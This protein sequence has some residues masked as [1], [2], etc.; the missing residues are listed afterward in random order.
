[1]KIIV[2]GL[3]ISSSWGNGHATLWRGLCKHIIRAGHSVLFFER[4]VSYY[5]GARDLIELPGGRLELFSAWDD[6]RSK[7]RAELREADAAIVTS[8][9]PDGIAATDLVLDQDRALRVFYDLDTPVTLA[10]LQAGEPLSY[11]GPRGLKE[12]D[13]VLSFTGGERVRAQF[14]HRLGARDVE[15]LYGH[16]DPDVHRPA[17]PQLHYR[18]HLSY[19]GTYSGDR[20]QALENL[21]IQPARDRPELQFLIGGAQYPHDFPWSRNIYFVRH[22]PPSKHPAFFASSRL[23]LNVTRRA[24][25]E[26][27]W[28]PSGRLFEAAACGAPILSDVWDGLAE[29][30]T[31]GEELIL[32]SDTPDVLAAM[33]MDDGQ[34][35]RI[36]RR[37]R[38]RVLEQHSSER[39]AMQ[40]IDFIERARSRSE[41]QPAAMEA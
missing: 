22:L 16:V 26:M 18:S 13:L 32:A 14:M 6:I 27:G 23:T 31:P 36:A 8:Y 29:F 4:D 25:A 34:L 24:M 15:P 38:E 21:F 37:A 12:F 5:A 30:F 33:E 11:V 41:R 17:D 10:N 28:C 7:A 39:R 35:L 3:T 19:L 1:M 2:F 40:L 9:C 20:Q